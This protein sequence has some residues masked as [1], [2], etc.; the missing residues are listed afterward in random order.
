MTWFLEDTTS[1]TSPG[2]EDTV[3]NPSFYKIK[4]LHFF[5]NL[6]SFRIA[7]ALTMSKID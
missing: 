3:S 7:I 5:K 2:W 6:F 1:L 4:I